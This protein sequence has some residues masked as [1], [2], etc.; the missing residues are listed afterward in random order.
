MILIHVLP[1]ADADDLRPAPPTVLTVRDVRWTSSACPPSGTDSVR[2]CQDAVKASVKIEPESVVF[3][4]FALPCGF[5]SE[6]RE[7]CCKVTRG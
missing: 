5:Q 3:D 2:G 1:F 7:W 6:L 4:G